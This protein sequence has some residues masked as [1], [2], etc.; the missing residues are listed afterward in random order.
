[1]KKQKTVKYLLPKDIRVSTVIKLK[2]GMILN[3]IDKTKYPDIIDKLDLLPTVEYLKLVQQLREETYCGKKSVI[4][5][6]EDGGMSIFKNV[7]YD[8]FP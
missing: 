1:M 7:A 6:Y 3:S 2:N 5:F 8:F 4:V